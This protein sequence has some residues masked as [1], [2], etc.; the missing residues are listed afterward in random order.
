MAYQSTRWD[1]HGKEDVS[2]INIPTMFNLDFPLWPSVSSTY[3]PGQ[4]VHKIDQVLEVVGQ[5]ISY[6]EK[7]NYR[8]VVFSLSL[9]AHSQNLIKNC[10]KKRKREGEGYCYHSYSSSATCYLSSW[11]LSFSRNK[12]ILYLFNCHQRQQHVSAMK[13]EEQQDKKGYSLM[14]GWT[15]VQSSC[16][17][18]STPSPVHPH[19]ELKRRCGS[20]SSLLQ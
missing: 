6:K 12:K 10:H 19:A 7:R 9:F 14:T 11:T 8:T 1:T 4:S 2:S 18:P 5:Y 13:R 15:F 16:C 17:P 20:P 3:G